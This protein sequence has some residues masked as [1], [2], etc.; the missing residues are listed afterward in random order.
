MRISFFISLAFL[1][2]CA[3]FGTLSATLNSDTAAITDTLNKYIV[4]TAD[5][6]PGM[7]QDAFHPE[8]NL[9]LVDPN[10]ALKKRDGQKYIEVFEDRKPR[11][12]VGKILMIDAV[13]DAAT[14]KVEILMPDQRVFT[15]YFLL[16]K[17]EGSWKIIHKSYTESKNFNGRGG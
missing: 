6:D 4:G 7:L 5:A 8:F 9:Y 1:A 10:G 14:A 17:I 16:M 3:S 12:R 11:A 15:D 13:N 2:G